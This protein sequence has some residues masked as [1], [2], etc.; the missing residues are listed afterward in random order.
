[1]H[2]RYVGNHNACPTP[3]TRRPRL[4]LTDKDQLHYGDSDPNNLGRHPR[5]QDAQR[6]P[7]PDACGPQAFARRI[8][9]TPFL[10]CFHVPL[11]IIKYSRD[12][13]PYCVVGRF[14]PHLSS[15]QGRRQSLRH[16]IATTIPHEKCSSM[17]RAPPHAQ[18]P[19]M[20]KLQAHLRRELSR[21][22]HAP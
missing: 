12:T 19:L 4:N 18:H 2:N 5:I 3:G 22:V 6:S 7:S 9:Q 11:N 20:G 15:R 8:W 21:H 13:K 16:P 14:L 1:V 10:A 17:A